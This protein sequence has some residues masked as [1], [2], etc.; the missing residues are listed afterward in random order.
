MLDIHMFPCFTDN[1]GYLVHDSESGETAC[2]DTP[3][4]EKILKELE[5]KKWKLT[6][7]LNTHHH[8][9]HAGG[10]LDIKKKTGCKII[11]PHGEAS[12]IPGIDQSVCE[13]DEIKL[14]QHI[15]KVLE[16]PGHTSG[17]II[18]HFIN[19]GTAFV[20]DTL[21]AMGCGRL[22]EGTAEQMWK[23]LQKIMQMPESTKMYCAHEY[24]LANARFAIT[25]DPDNTALKNR[26]DEVKKLR[27]KN[28]S[29]IPTTL[30]NE[31]NTNP[32]LRVKNSDIRKNL[33]MAKNSDIDVFAEIRARKDNF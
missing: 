5:K 17:H 23:S 4:P 15:A 30:I 20:G 2:I 18:Y 6:C 12:S 26:F 22:F 32:F 16:T 27:D 21:F 28:I 31:L 1:Y 8:W 7:I 10:N 24:T 9:D 25:V 29:T 19:D 11:G 13:G 14:G 33:N 3:E